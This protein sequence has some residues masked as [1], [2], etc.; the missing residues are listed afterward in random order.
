MCCYLYVEEV[1]GGL[2][3]LFCGT[4]FQTKKSVLET[5]N[6]ANK[7]KKQKNPG[8]HLFDSICELLLWLLSVLSDKNAF[9]LL[10]PSN[11]S[12]YEPHKSLKAILLCL[13]SCV[14][15]Y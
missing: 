8:F 9:A 13:L 1:C 10:S 5:T 12:S 3:R 7:E 11:T 4:D 6:T 14:V 2:T 15:K